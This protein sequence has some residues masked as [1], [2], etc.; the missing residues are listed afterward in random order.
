[1]NLVSTVWRRF[2]DPMDGT[3][4]FIVF[5]IIGLALLVLFSASN[6]NHDRIQ[7]QLVSLSIALSIMWVTANIPPQRL[8]SLAVPIYIFGVLLLIG[9]ALFGD[10]SKGAR[11]WLDLGFIRIQ[12]SEM[13]KIAMPMMLAWYFQQR[14]GALMVRDYF[15]AALILLVPAALILRQPDLGTALL[16]LTAG[17]YVIFLAGL[18]WKL[19]VPVALAGVV[20]I[21]AL[22]LSGDAI[23]Q[24]DVKWPGLHDYQK[25]RVCTLLD[26]TKDPLGKGFHIIQSTIAVG[27]GGIAG[28][29]WLRGTQTHLE[30]LP[31]RHTD[32]IFAVLAEEFGLIGACLLIALYAMLIARGLFIAA[33]APTLFSRLLAGS[34]TLAFFTY[35]FV[36]IG[37][38]SGILPVVGVPLPF[39]SFG[40][41]A[42]VTLCLGLGILMSIHRNRMLV[43][44]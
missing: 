41:T 5:S 2:T 15:V 39:M 37:M 29:G 28:K 3:L 23:C 38:V 42:L 4:L 18:S 12:P 19:I 30:F 32:F 13:M 24:P 20:G 40:G 36:N 31:E 27:S 25:Q 16:V 14:E 6:D 7:T 21:S 35:S 10:I 8:M 9:V 34:L 11:R 22:V 1:M 26:P 33:E 17:F 44:K 43:Q